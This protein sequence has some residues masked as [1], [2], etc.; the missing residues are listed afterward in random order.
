[1]QVGSKSDGGE[2]NRCGESRDIGNE[3]RHETERGMIDLREIGVLTTG[4]WYPSRQLRVT[5][6]AA[7]RDQATKKP[8]QQNRKTA[9]K[10][11][12]LEAETRVDASPD[13]G[14]GDQRDAGK[15]A[16]F[17][18]IASGSRGGVRRCRHKG[19]QPTDVRIN[20]KAPVK[21]IILFCKKNSPSSNTGFNLN[22]Q[23]LS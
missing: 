8:D 4:A 21:S 22:L 9:L 18:F 15:K 6:G 7:E 19:H 10:I 17:A 13:H 1:M 12:Q 14:R 20:E 16:N 5:E 23:P 3:P 11:E 2:G